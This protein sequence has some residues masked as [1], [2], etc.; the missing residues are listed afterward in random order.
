MSQTSFLHSFQSSRLKSGLDSSE[1]ERPD[2]AG[3]AAGARSGA[4]LLACPHALASY[5]YYV[6]LDALRQVLAAVAC[7]NINFGLGKVV[8]SQDP[9]FL[10]A[11]ST[12][13][14]EEL[15]DL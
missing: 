1:Q 4:S 2:G 8:R 13:L 3:S 11:W 10:A 5:A 14:L 6:Y 15:L 12:Y 7:C 9:C